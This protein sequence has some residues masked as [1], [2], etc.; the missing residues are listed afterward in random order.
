V[1]SRLE[2]VIEERK[3][4]DINLGG[5]VDHTLIGFAPPFNGC[6]TARRAFS[7]NR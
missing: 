3:C 5:D 2:Q 6:A 4:G 1:L 7:T